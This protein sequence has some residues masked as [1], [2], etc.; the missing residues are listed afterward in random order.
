MGPGLTACVRFATSVIAAQVGLFCTGE[1]L[2]ISVRVYVLPGVVSARALEDGLTAVD[3]LPQEVVKRTHT[4][5]VIR[6]DRV[7][8]VERTHHVEELEHGLTHAAERGVIIEGQ[9]ARLWVEQNG[10]ERGA[11]IAVLARE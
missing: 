11:E 9:R 6:A 4:H 5:G 8:V 10:S 3:L 7:D 1:L 2:R